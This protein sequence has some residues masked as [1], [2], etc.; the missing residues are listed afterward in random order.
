MSSKG[1]FTIAQGYE[2][3]R[4]AYGMALSLKLSQPEELSKLSIG[5]SS[6]DMKFINGRHRE[7]FD[8]IIEIPWGDHAA[9][10]QWKLEN[11]WKVIHM[12]P[13]DE[14]IKLDADM[15]FPSD[16]SLWWDYLSESDGVF[17]TKPRTY[18]GEII[19]SDYYRKTFTESRLPNIYTAFFYFKRNDVNFEL[20]KLAE[21]IFNNWQRCFYEFL[22]PDHRPKHVSTDVVFAIAAKIMDYEQY[23]RLPHMD[24]ATFVHMKSQLQF[25]PNDHFMIEDWTRMIPYYF[26]RDATLKIGN[27]VQ[28]LPFHYHVK[29]FLTDRMIN[30]MERKLGL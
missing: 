18:R 24:I 12:T 14:T 23:N 5:V 8:Q 27:Y 30:I 15:L 25:W 10:S 3:Q 2:Y 21:F 26:N 1:Y 17:A 22:E 11:E 9:R 19:T 7:V 13:Y 29:T 28:T 4:L 20:F 16:I 6:D